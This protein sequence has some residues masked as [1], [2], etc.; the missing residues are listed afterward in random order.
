MPRSWLVIGAL[1]LI[2]CKEP[3]PPPPPPTTTTVTPPVAPVVSVPSVARRV[4]PGQADAPRLALG[5]NGAVATQ[6]GHATD[7][8]IGILK[9]G[10]N[11][12][13]AAIAVAFALAVTHPSAGNIGGGGFMVVR[14][15]DG[16]A[17]T[18]DYREVAP[19]RATRN[20]YLGA[21]GE[22]NGESLVGAKAAGIPGTVAGMALAHERFGK[23]SWRDLV[24]P[25]VRLARG[26]VI[27]SHHAKD[28]TYAVKRMKAEGFDTSAALFSKKDAT[29]WEAGDTFVQPAL[30]AT[31]TVIA[32]AGAKGFYV[33][34]VAK[35]MVDE[36]K[37][38]GGIWELEDLAG[39]VAVERKPVRFAYRGHEVVTMPPPSGGG[40]V[41]RHLL[42]AAEQ[43]RLVDKPWPDPIATH[44]YVESARRAYADR[45]TLLADPDH[46]RLPLQRLL[47]SD[48][49]KTRMGDI[50]LAKATPSSAVRAGV[51]SSPQS[52][53]TT[54]FSIVDAAGNAVANTYTLNTGFGSK[55]ILRDV[56]VLLNNE[57][58]D[59][60]AKP[61]SANVYGLVQS[62]PN[63][64]APGKRMLSSMT[65]TIVVKDGAARL[66]VGSPGGPT[67]TT[68]VA[69]IIRHVIDHTMTVEQAVAAPRIHHQWLPDL[70]YVEAEVPNPVRDALIALG[71]QIKERPPIGHANCIEIDPTT[72]GFRAVADVH[73]DGG[74]AAAY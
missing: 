65:P 4:P 30:A 34:D 56:G 19:R 60:S 53:E 72:H 6:E 67:I 42:A 39:Y 74:K 58:D 64:I 15:A 44:V 49:L 51:T 38:G 40:V 3:A 12:V 1:V 54:H 14:M 31:L 17:S 13:D 47:A 37:S 66:V 63:A 50:D 61:G 73:R 2:T 68:T 28:L 57:M 5:A 18:I 21:D 48:Y 43:H 36:I 29:P 70:V 35:K 22:V 20:M 8:G 52:E 23:L 24:Q 41:L 9:K 45:N 7:V 16:R 55:L 26:H 71:H 25:A 11:A 33:G 10:G 59:F 69:Q 62:E 27:D 32:T 46:A